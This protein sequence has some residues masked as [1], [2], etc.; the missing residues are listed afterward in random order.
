M[1][2]ANQNII[3]WAN[4]SII[5]LDEAKAHLRVLGTDDDAYITSIIK[6]AYL[7]AENYCNAVLLPR[8]DGTGENC[9]Q[10]FNQA[11]LLIIGSMYELRSNEVVGTIVSRIPQNAYWVLNQFRT[12][13]V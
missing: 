10:L 11:V 12:Y 3:D 6:A 7:H 9:D 2:I 1:P 8:T 5:T 13:P 4:A